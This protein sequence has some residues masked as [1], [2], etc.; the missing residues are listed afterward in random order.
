MAGQ[1]LAIV[2]KTIAKTQPRFQAIA[3]AGGGYVN[4]ETEA[5]YAK[6]IIR[7]SSALMRCE[8]H[9]IEDA[10]MNI[11]AIGLSLNPALQHAALIPRRAS[12]KKTYCHFD[13]MYR[14]LI[15]LA[16]DGGSI[17]MIQAASVYE[18]EVH[19]GNFKMTRGTDPQVIHNVDPLMKKETMGEIV[20]AYCVAEIA[21]SHIK[22]TSWMPIDEIEEI[23]ERSEAW[24]SGKRGPWKTDFQEMCVKTV[25][26]RG[27]KQWPIGNERLDRAIALANTAEGY[28]EPDPDDI[29][30]EVDTRPKITELQDKELRDLCRRAQLRVARV[31]EKYEIPVMRMLPAEKFTE[32]RT[33]CLIAI[34]H[35]ETKNAEK[36]TVL[37]AEDYGLK[38][39]VL[40]GIAANYESKATLRRKREPE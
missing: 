26:K 16:T 23:R 7:R 22:H 39:E 25:I 29:Q 24:K 32:C 18:E 1:T 36:G 20:G 11:A 12:D 8:V 19:A 3:K 6:Q 21:G 27:R 40:D 33:N 14:G 17:L 5:R 31:Y 15:K 2:E 13:P 10:V 38:L 28:I 9:S 35:H 37:Y 34:A 4:F 30:G